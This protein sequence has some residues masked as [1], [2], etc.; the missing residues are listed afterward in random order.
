MNKENWWCHHL[1]YFSTTTQEQK[2]CNKQT[3]S[4]NDKQSIQYA[5]LADVLLRRFVL[6]ASI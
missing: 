5:Q 1:L 6:R 2:I 4:N 3:T